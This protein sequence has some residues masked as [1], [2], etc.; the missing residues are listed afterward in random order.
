LLHGLYDG[1]DFELLLTM[2]PQQATRLV[3]DL[4]AGDLELDCPVSIIGQVTSEGGLR[5]R[6]ADGAGGERLID[7]PEGG[8]QH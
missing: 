7:V 1:E 3:D 4:S 6:I 5:V 8:Y 2:E